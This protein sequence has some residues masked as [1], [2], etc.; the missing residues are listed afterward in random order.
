MSIDVEWQDENGLRL[1]RYDGPPIGTSF[2]DNAPPSAQ[3][4][5]FVDP[6]GDTTFN[7]AQI[8][9]LES[10]LALFVNANGVLAEQARSLLQFISSRQDRTHLY[11]KFIGD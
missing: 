6:Y 2:P 1:A 3:C 10:E 11:I 8:A 4:M 9:C 7:A 5:C